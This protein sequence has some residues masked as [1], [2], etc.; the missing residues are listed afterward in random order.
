MKKIIQLLLLLF[1]LNI[2]GQDEKIIKQYKTYSANIINDNFFH[3]LDSIVENVYKMKYKYYLLEIW[4]KERTKLY[5]IPNKSDSILYLSVRGCETPMVYGFH[6]F[7][8]VK[9]RGKNYFVD[10]G[11]DEILVKKYKKKIYV[12]SRQTIKK[13]MYKDMNSPLILV[14]YHNRNLSVV[15]DS[16]YD[17]YLVE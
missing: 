4:N 3:Q 7:F 16:R 14:E 13:N 11:A 12:L 1:A 15:A 17:K 5:Y 2:Y 8:D 9:Y 6:Q 10:S